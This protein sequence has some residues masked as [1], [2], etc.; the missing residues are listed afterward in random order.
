MTEFSLQKR[1]ERSFRIRIELE[2]D[3]KTKRRRFHLETVRGGPNEMVKDVKARAKARAIELLDKLNKGEHV[4]QSGLTI[5][6]YMAS[7]LENPVD[8][9]PKTV[10]R[11]RQ[12]AEQQ[13]YPHLGTI[14]LQKLKGDD[15]QTWHATLRSSGGKNGKPL[16]ARTVGHAHRLLHAT[17]GRALRG[18]VV[19]RN[20]ANGIKPPKV[21]GDE[22]EALDAIQARDVL[23][24]LKD[25]AFL[26]IVS[27]ALGT[28]L[29][30]GEILALRWQDID[31]DAAILT[32]ER[33]LEET[34]GGLRFKP[35]KSKYGR[36]SVAMPATA[37][38]ALRT[39]RKAQLELRL[40]LGLGKP[41]DDALVFCTVEGEPMSPDKLSRDWCRLVKARKLPRVS[42]HA[43]R[44]T[45]VS[46]LIDA[47][48]NVFSISRRIGHGSPAITLRVYAHKFK[49]RDTEAVDAIEA[50]M[51]R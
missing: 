24:K 48:L 38:E 21:E 9:S 11:Y 8:L 46:A 31:L 12:L 50:V 23:D 44:H 41:H 45:H 39:H 5:K 19:F 7:W 17:L 51:R 1:G 4:E 2:R 43:L 3:T 15:V 33:S 6:A 49:P 22:I 28:G 37:I 10:E 32:V 18:G 30:R 42:F 14:A 34:K 25:H 27:V 13:I 20:V 40:A 26:P 35:P 29:R 47:G 36:R 16:S